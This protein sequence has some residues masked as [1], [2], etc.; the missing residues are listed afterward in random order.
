[1]VGRTRK[2][3]TGAASACAAGLKWVPRAAN[4][5]N[6]ASKQGCPA[7]VVFYL[8]AL[9][10]ESSR[11]AEFFLLFLEHE[12]AFDDGNVSPRSKTYCAPTRH[13]LPVL[14][15]VVDRQQSK[16]LIPSGDV[17]SSGRRNGRGFC[18]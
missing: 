12:T 14:P 7:V 18:V 6:L 3:E 1:M 9:I 16:R 15:T 10:E 13:G 4:G 11:H 17:I 2:P 5:R 8:N